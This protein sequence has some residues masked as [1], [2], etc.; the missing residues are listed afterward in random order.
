MLAKSFAEFSAFVLD[1]GKHCTYHTSI[2]NQKDNVPQ[3]AHG[4]LILML[5]GTVCPI[6]FVHDVLV[7]I[8]FTPFVASTLSISR[9]K[10]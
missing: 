7:S 1:I 6:T 9:S 4:M 5:E 10:V 8:L 3:N 2:K